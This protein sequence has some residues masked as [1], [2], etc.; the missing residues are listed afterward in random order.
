MRKNS[1][2]AICLVAVFTGGCGPTFNWREFTSKDATYQVLFPA[3]PVSHTRDVHLDGVSVSMTMA[4]A[5]VDDILFAVG[6]AEAPDAATAA[7]SLT[8]MQSALVRNIGATVTRSKAAATPSSSKL[9][10]EASGSR[11]GRPMRLIGHFESRGRRIYQ[12]VMA[13]PAASVKPEQAEQ[14]MSSFKP[15]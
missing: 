15:L 6:T 3:K 13:G 8:A 1:L 14:F 7:K 2:L 11:N 4:A 5:E 10:I 12:V 9:D